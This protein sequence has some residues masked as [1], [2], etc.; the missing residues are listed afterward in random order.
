M[1]K[2]I[3]RIIFAFLLLATA[4]GWSQTV[5][6]RSWSD[7]LPAFTRMSE[8]VHVSVDSIVKLTPI[9]GT[10][11]EPAGY[12]LMLYGLDWSWPE[13]ISILSA[14][15]IDYRPFLNSDLYLVTDGSGRRVIELDP[16]IANPEVVWEFKGELGTDKYLERPVD[17]Y[18]YIQDDIRRVLI[19]DQGRHRV[20][21]VIRENNSIEWQYG[22]E[23]EGSGYNQLRNPAD[24]VAIPDSGFIVICDKGNNRVIFVREFNKSIAWNWGLGELNNP[25]DVEYIPA[26]REVLITDQGKHRVIKVNRQTNA[27]SW[28][29]G[30]GLP[31]SG[32]DGL[33]LP[34]DADVLANGNILICDNGN[35]RLIEVNGSGDIV[36]QFSR[37]LSELKDADRM[38]SNK[39]IIV[40]KNLPSRIGYTST[41]DSSEF[42]DLG[43]E[44][45]F[46]SLFWSGDTISGVT[47]IKLQIRS[48]NNLAALET[49]TYYGP[50]GTNDYYT[51][52]M[53]PI[54]TIHSGHRFYQFLAILETS[55]PLYTPRLDNVKVT[56]KYYDT[57]VTGVI[58]SEQI[59]DPE[60]YII[61][62]WKTLTI[63]SILPEKASYRKD[64]HINFSIVSTVNGQTL[65]SDFTDAAY[66][67]KTIDLSTVESLKGVQSIQLKASFTSDFPAVTPKLQD[68]TIT[69]DATQATA[70]AISFVDADKN[71][72]DYYRV[73]ESFQPGQ[74]YIDRVTLFLSDPN[75]EQ[76]QDVVSLDVRALLSGDN[77]RVNL[78]RQTAGGYL[79]QPSI[80]AIIL[81]TGVPIS[82]NGYLEVFNR[83]TLTV[84]YSDPTTLLDT[85][86]D[87]VIIIEDTAGFIQFES[88]NHAVI[89]S[90]SIG[91]TIFVRILDEYD[92]NLSPSQDTLAIVAFDHGT[93]DQEEVLLVEMPDSSGGYQSGEFLSIDGLPLEL[94]TT[95]VNNDGMIQTVAGSEI[96]INYDDSIN[97]LPIL[98][99]RQASSLPDTLWNLGGGPLHFDVAPNPFYGDRH[100]ILRIRASSSIG[101]LM[102]PRIEI[103]NL[104]GQK[105][106][107][108]DGS[109]L[110]FYNSYPIPLNQ[111]SLADNWWDMKD[112]FGAAVSSGTY[113]VKM[114]G[115]IVGA[116]QELST[117]K[118]IVIVR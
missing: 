21:K 1:K 56:Y 13:E 103:Y 30:T 16:N 90:A 97:Q 109:Q 14:E 11:E 6:S 59:R 77:Q 104:A 113:F 19:T 54:N 68:W 88:Q 87:S 92:Q 31:T 50:T 94:N 93:N 24:A 86:S 2:I 39:S 38:N 61:T 53:T 48:E 79:L 8:S 49:A 71:A 108:I 107:E 33:N 57:D 64:A 66:E 44:V 114:F 22:D 7:G 101:D 116:D 84:S 85:V 47:S 67:T 65:L 20:I 81:K 83:D 43:Q 37:S 99:V 98:Q 3:A 82:E 89:D 80:P 41:A 46:D 72:T 42:R 9:Y 45:R 100:S 35:N 105:I 96:G 5:L 29:F 62:K 40:T 36:W 32:S 15:D 51:Q 111:F 58:L 17:S 10:Y 12:Q 4:E 55:N 60:E 63:N 52:T 110:R 73:S 70:A 118:K 117:I 75:F 112:Q 26:T 76:I 74:Q 25:V 27:I 95:Q 106:R 91:D 102:I 78:T 34:T 115:R 18:M 28:Q 23:T 69:W